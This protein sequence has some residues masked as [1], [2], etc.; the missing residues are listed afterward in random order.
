MKKQ[1][2]DFLPKVHTYGKATLFFDNDTLGTVFN[3]YLKQCA[4][5]AVQPSKQDL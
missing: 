5:E 3:Q 4:Q 1:K 2:N